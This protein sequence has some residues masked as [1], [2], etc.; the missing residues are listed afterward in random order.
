MRQIIL[1]LIIILATVL[2]GCSGDGAKQLFD[3]AKLEELQDNQEHATKLY[4]EIIER[5]PESEYA[6]KAKE[7]LSAL[8]K[9]DKRK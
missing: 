3:T 9:T 8:G 6:R 4:Q 1:I 5:Y 2:S 7:R